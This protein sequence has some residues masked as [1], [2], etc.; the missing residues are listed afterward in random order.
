METEG[1]AWAVCEG[2]ARSKWGQA[3]T[4]NCRGRIKGAYST[5][6]EESAWLDLGFT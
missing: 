1:N 3:T 4:M 2:Q 5:F 6:K